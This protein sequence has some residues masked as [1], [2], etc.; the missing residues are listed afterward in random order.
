MK[1]QDLTKQQKNALLKELREEEA[2]QKEQRK[3]YK[4]KVDKVVPTIFEKLHKLSNSI[5]QVKTDVYKSLEGL[6]NEKGEVYQRDGEEQQSHSFT[7]IDGS[8]TITIGYRVNDG[9]DDT[10]NVGIAK[11]N[12]FIQTLAKDKASRA[13]VDTILQL[14]SKDAKGNLKAS[15]VLQLQKMAE[16]FNNTDFNDAIN[17]IKDAYR[18]VRTKQFVSVRYKDERGEVVEL[19][20]SIT[21][22]PL[23]IEK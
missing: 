9:W 22:A 11:V 23:I 14:L 3:A 4:E 21:D 12:E 6:V 18:P 10:I 19:P 1:L 8:K 16:E 20:L 7:S 5:A 15:R 2:Q 17:I 13:L